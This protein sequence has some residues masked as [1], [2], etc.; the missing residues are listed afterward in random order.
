MVGTQQSVVL[1]VHSR[2]ADGGADLMSYL[3]RCVMRCVADRQLE[4]LAEA[5]LM[6]KLAHPSPCAT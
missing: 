2:R 4:F 6:V 5:A 1:C 3:L